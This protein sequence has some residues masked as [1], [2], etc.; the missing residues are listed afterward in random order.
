[1][2]DKEY[3]ANQCKALK[4]G[5]ERYASGK[6]NDIKRLTLGTFSPE[7]FAQIM[8]GMVKLGSEYYSKCDIDYE[9]SSMLNK[10]GDLTTKL[11]QSEAKREIQSKSM[12]V[13]SHLKKQLDSISREDYEKRFETKRK[14]IITQLN[15]L[16]K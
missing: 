11:I 1:M 15:K 13:L 7:N 10:I 2:P 6:L 12:G 14:A 3:T 5:Y 9:K 16:N 8:F 4:D